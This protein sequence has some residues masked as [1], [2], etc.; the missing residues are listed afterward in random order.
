MSKSIITRY[1]DYS[2]FS[3][4]PRECIHHCIFGNGLRQLA[5]TDG[6]WIPLLNREHNASSKGTIYQIHGNPAAEKFSKMLGQTA[7]ESQYLAYKLEQAAID[8]SLIE[9]T[10]D[11]W[12]D[13]AREEFRK[14][15]GQSWL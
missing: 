15:Y 13:K 11:E 12:R 9:K 7:W 8:G 4:T 5:D 10:A 2:I 6:V 3:G 1:E 14:R